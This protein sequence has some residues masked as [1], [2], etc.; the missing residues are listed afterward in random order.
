MQT[1]VG[2]V[3]GDPGMGDAQAAFALGSALSER[4]RETPAL[5]DGFI[6]LLST[7]G[8]PNQ[9]A[10]RIS[11]LMTTTTNPNGISDFTKGYQ[12]QTVDTM[13]GAALGGASAV[14]TRVLTNAVSRIPVVAVQAPERSA[15][16]V[17][18]ALP[19]IPVV[20]VQAPERSTRTT[21]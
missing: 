12:R 11:N 6:A 21:T 16:T 7:L 10:G 15:A 3:H 8:E 1:A 19:E 13:M 14:G 18:S 5:N 20:A 4:F 17:P 2:A 9:I